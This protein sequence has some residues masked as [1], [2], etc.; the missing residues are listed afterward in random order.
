MSRLRCS[1][2]VSLGWLR[3]RHT[4]DLARKFY[5]PCCAIDRN[6]IP[7]AHLAS[8][9]RVIR[10]ICIYHRAR[11]WER[12]TTRFHN[13]SIM[14]TEWPLPMRWPS[15]LSAR[16]GF[17]YLKEDFVTKTGRRTLRCQRRRLHSAARGAFHAFA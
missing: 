6:S 1:K 16:R 11:R 10:A 7:L 3:L 9:L 17:I 5:G 12:L 2:H 4:T 8:V 13:A 14:M 15:M